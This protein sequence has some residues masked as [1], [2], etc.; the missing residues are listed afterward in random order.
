M[1][2]SLSCPAH[3]DQRG[4]GR[5]GKGPTS[6][7]EPWQRRAVGGAYLTDRS[8]RFG[9]TNEVLRID[10]YGSAW[11]GAL[12]PRH[13]TCSISNQKCRTNTHRF[14]ATRARCS[15]DQ[16][17]FNAGCAD[18]LLYGD[19]HWCVHARVEIA[20]HVPV[21]KDCRLEA[22]DAFVVALAARAVLVLLPVAVRGAASVRVAPYRA[23]NRRTA[24][25]VLLD[26][27]L[28]VLGHVASRRCVGLLAGRA[29]L[30]VGGTADRPCGICGLLICGWLADAGPIG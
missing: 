25:G 8:A 17:D 12:R 26:G 4:G 13:R 9:A 23:G 30:A 10:G 15:R 18:A 5:A 6:R 14:A 19:T 16:C 27:R 29:W 11:V 24:W 28:W 7:A 21:S 2:R 3:G 1:G 22:A 20:E